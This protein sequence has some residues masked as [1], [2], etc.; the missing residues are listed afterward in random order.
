MNK[1]GEI[2]RMSNTIKALTVKFLLTFGAAYLTV[3]LI[4]RNPLGWVL[5]LALLGT[6]LNYLI[7]DLFILKRTGN[8][9][10]AVMDGALSG[11]SFIVVV[12]RRYRLQRRPRKHTRPN[13][14]SE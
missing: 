9:F 14:L 1:R 4:N 2:P 11:L 13:I 8:I 3:G 12:H 10:A 7:G 6:F 5:I